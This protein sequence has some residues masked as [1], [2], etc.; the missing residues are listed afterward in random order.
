LSARLGGSHD[1]RFQTSHL[2]LEESDG[3]IELVAAKRVA[4][5]QLRQSIGLVNRGGAGGAH[6]VEKDGD[7]ARRRLPRSLAAGEAAPHDANGHQWAILRLVDFRLA[8]V[9]GLTFARA[10]TFA[11]TGSVDR[12]ARRGR[13]VPAAARPR[14]LAR[15][16][17][18]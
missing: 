18:L 13:E 5:D 3:V 15:G 11:P 6:L 4:A 17:A 10:L 1:N 7:A 12:P 14:R 8:D 2:L 9:R 16:G